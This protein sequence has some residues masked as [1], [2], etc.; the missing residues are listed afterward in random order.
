MAKQHRLFLKQTHFQGD[1]PMQYYYPQAAQFAPQGYWGDRIVDAAPIIGGIVGGGTT[2]VTENPLIGG[3][4]G[5][6]ANVAAREF[7]EWL[8]YSA[9]PTQ[10]VYAAQQPIAADPAFAPQGAIGSWLGR[11]VGGAVGGHYGQRG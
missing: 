2:L 3:I 9:Y 1:Y 4:A 11:T 8:P 10:P 6:V 7:G 5:G